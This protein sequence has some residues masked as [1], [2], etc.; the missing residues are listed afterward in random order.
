[1]DAVGELEKGRES[2][3]RRAWADAYTHLSHADRAAPLGAE[4]LDLLATAAHML[5][6]DDAVL[7]DLERAHHAHLEDGRPLRAARCAFWLGLNFAMRGRMSPSTGWFARAQRLLEREDRDCVERGYLLIPA[8]LRHVAAGEAEAAYA[9]GADAAAIGERFGDADL[10]A[11]AV[12]EQGF[13]LVR[14]G[15]VEEGLWLLDEA[16][17]AVTT[18]ELSPI[19]TGLVYCNVIAGCQEI[20][21]VRR[22]QEWTAALTRW[23]EQQPEMVAHTGLCLVHRAEIMQLHGAWPDALDE[24][25][26]AGE[27]FAQ[28]AQGMNESAAAQ[29]LYRQGELHR[30]RGD[31]AEAEEAYRRASRG[32][33]G[34][35]AGPRPAATGSGKRRSG[36]RCDPAC[37]G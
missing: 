22:A 17:V 36:E 3:A 13:A 33:L 26:R 37:S 29:A 25:R 24:A 18:G 2:Y 30:L 16:M 8:L 31:F 35:A 14:Q 15:R 19:V 12:H 27:R 10:V 4:D 9:T 5:G 28:R 11:M 1:M 34:A 32:G 21:E 23:C 7:T 20:F 6:R